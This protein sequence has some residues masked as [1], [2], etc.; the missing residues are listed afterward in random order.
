MEFYS[1][2]LYNKP[3]P[4]GYYQ[5]NDTTEFGLLHPDAIEALNAWYDMVKGC[6]WSN[7][8]KFTTNDLQYKIT[9]RVSASNG[10]N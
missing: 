6:D 2:Y 7:I 10:E 8:K 1:K 4:F 3:L 5:Q 9:R